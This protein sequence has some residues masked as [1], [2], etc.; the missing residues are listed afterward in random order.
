MLASHTYGRTLY[1]PPESRES[2]KLRLSEIRLGPRCLHCDFISRYRNDNRA[3]RVITEAR[4]I[5]RIARM[6]W[7]LRDRRRGRGSKTGA[8]CCSGTQTSSLHWPRNKKDAGCNMRISY[9]SG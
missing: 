7:M 2:G 5:E 3:Q 6:G 1:P 8:E 9:S 4:V